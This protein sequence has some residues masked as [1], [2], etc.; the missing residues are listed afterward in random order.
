M[1]SDQNRVGILDDI[2]LCRLLK[3]IAGVQIGLRIDEIDPT[4]PGKNLMKNIYK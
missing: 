2:R 1:V 4:K 3:Y